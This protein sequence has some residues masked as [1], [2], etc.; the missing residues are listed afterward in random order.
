VLQWRLI[1]FPGIYEFTWDPGRIIFLG[2][3]YS[4]L[5]I[6]LATMTIATVRALRAFRLR[7][8]E[9]VRWHADFDD[10]PAAARRCRHEIGGEIASRACERGFDCGRCPE[11]AR[12]L[13]ELPHPLATLAAPASAAIV[14]GIEVPGDR[15]YHRGHTWVREEQ[16]GTLTVGLDGLG[17]RLLGSAEETSLPPVGTHL[18]RNGLAWRARKGDADV[19]VL[20]P[21]DGEVVAT[22]RPSQ[23]WMLRLR[24]AE[25]GADLRHLLTPAEARPWMLR[26]M[27]RLQM[28]LAIDGMGPTLADGGVPIDD[29]SSAIP[30]EHLDEVCGLMFLEP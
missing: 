1:V 30:P 29:M 10:L 26:E 6:V 21:V 4:V 17:S 14:A 23:G 19:R 28:S 12:F 16:D 18:I 9:S 27:E 15:L 20:A 8:A 11:H 24:P 25:G 22:G 2:A 5:A 13:A 3:F 7:N